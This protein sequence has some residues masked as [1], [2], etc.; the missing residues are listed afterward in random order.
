MPLQELQVIAD[1]W[2]MKVSLAINNSVGHFHIW[3]AVLCAII[4]G[5][6][7]LMVE[8]QALWQAAERWFHRLVTS[9]FFGWMFSF[10][11]CVHGWEPTILACSEMPGPL[12]LWGGHVLL[13]EGGRKILKGKILETG[14]QWTSESWSGL[15]SSVPLQDI[16]LLLHKMWAEA[17]VLF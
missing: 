5:P 4:H 11:A 14:I 8:V 1:S 3:T 10:S 13:I 9:K 7:N 6:G 2:W 12:P 15:D 16:A 17:Q